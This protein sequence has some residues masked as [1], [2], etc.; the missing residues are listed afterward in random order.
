MFKDN[1][2]TPVHDLDT[3]KNL[4]RLLGTLLYG[5]ENTLKDDW[6]IYGANQT[7][8]NIT[9][10]GFQAATEDDGQ[11]HRCEVIEA[12]FKDPANGI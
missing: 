8:L 4:Q 11:L 12:A 1:E 10:D 7:F 5:N 9:A 6:P 2:T 3:S